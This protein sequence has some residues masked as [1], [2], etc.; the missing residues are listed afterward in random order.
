MHF[1]IVGDVHGQAHKLRALLKRMGY[2]ER[3]GAM[4]H[5][6][7][8]VIFVGD[9]VDRGPHQM[10]TI[11]IVRSMMDAGSALAVMGN[12]EFNAIAWY[13][14]D[15]AQ[16]G[17]YLRPRR[18]EVGEKNRHQ[19]A[20]FLA[21]VEHRPCL[22]A[23]IIDWFLSLPLWLELPDLRVVH[24]CWHPEFMAAL[25][26]HL[27]PGRLLD[28]EMMIKA[29]RRGSKEYRQVETLLKG[30]EVKLPDGCSFKDKSG[31]TRHEA[32]TR[33]WDPSA[34]TYRQ[35]A[36][37]PPHDK[38]QLPDTEIP[39]SARIGY[40]GDK[41]VFLGHY[42]LTGR[43]EVLSPTV[44]CVDYSAGKGGPLVAYRWSGESILSSAN[45][46]SSGDE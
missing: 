6:E 31:I 38:A 40:S 23:E 26:P 5:P 28:E 33:W 11:D 12:H 10:E 7:R 16:S 44:A 15:P 32:R 14:R 34:T 13:M 41:P 37:V 20:A 1:D 2:A 19:H 3:N 24:A 27:K 18:G 46:E 22:H 9:F 39:G 30:I 29:S 35:A 43:P 45:F 36:F 25:E 17:E 8:T 21:E 42:W 4:R